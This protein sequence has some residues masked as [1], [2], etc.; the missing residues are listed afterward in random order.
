MPESMNGGFNRS[1]FNQLLYERYVKIWEAS[2]TP[3]QAQDAFYATNFMYTPWPYLEDENL[4]RDAF[5]QVRNY[6]IRKINVPVI[7]CTS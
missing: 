2:M 4:N 3:Q 6:R 5:V 1:E 7:L